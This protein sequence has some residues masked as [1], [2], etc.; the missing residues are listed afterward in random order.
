MTVHYPRPPVWDCTGCDQP[1]P[2]EPRRD[3]LLREYAGA[4]QALHIYMAANMVQAAEDM[5]GLPAGALHERFAA[6]VRAAERRP[7]GRPVLEGP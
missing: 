2:C 4:I 7:D 6:W 1:W 5:P 3:E